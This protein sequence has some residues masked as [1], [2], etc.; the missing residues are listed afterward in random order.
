[1]DASLET[2]GATV[3]HAVNQVASVTPGGEMSESAKAEAAELAEAA[4]AAKD[5][6]AAEEGAPPEEPEPGNLV[7]ADATEAE[8][9][10]AAAVEAEAAAGRAAEAASLATDAAVATSESVAAVEDSKEPSPAGEAV[11]KLTVHAQLEAESAAAAADAAAVAAVKSKTGEEAE[12]AAA[13]AAEEANTAVAAAEVAVETATTVAE[14]AAAE[15]AVAVAADTTPPPAPLPPID[16]PTTYTVAPPVEKEKQMSTVAMI[17]SLLKGIRIGSDLT[18]VA[19]PPI[20]NTPKSQLQMF[21]E[22]AGRTSKDI[23]GACTQGKTPVERFLA[24]VRW[25]L[26]TTRETAFGK[27]PYNPILGETHHVSVGDLNLQLEQVCH[28]PPMTAIRGVREPQKLTLTWWHA[29]TPK[30]YGSWMEAE[31]RGRRTLELGEH[32]E[33]YV[34]TS[35]SISFRFFPIVGTEW[36]GS[37]TIK[38]EKTG[39]E[40]VVEYKP[41]AFFGLSGAENRVGG[42]VFETA[43]KKVLYTLEG[44]WDKT[45]SI[46]SAADKTTSVLYNHEDACKDLAALS[47]EDPKG[48]VPT[49]SILVWSALTGAL[50]A[51]DYETARVEKAK[52]ENWQREVRAKRQAAKET[53]EPTFFVKDPT[54]HWVW[55]DPSLT[56]GHAPLV[57]PT[58]PPLEA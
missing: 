38:C 21:A 4:E 36:V 20:F 16:A 23:L 45:V 46:K 8:A 13:K 33:V 28:H 5:S 42:K 40:A 17:I 57:A 10:T 51:K 58:P 14:T 15:A 41:R 26:S 9:V 53:W 31:V 29:P 27:A 37:T 44:C 48:L 3:E 22:S 30:Y 43:T 25:H 56:V 11:I 2:N 50:L 47:V 32:G 34:S 24:V 49:E 12:A 39:L 18:K 7:V 19:V 6:E 1:M 55:K 54:G 52:V 35:P